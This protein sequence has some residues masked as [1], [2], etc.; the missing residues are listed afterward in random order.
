[1][2]ETGDSVALDSAKLLQSDIFQESR[3]RLKVYTREYLLSF[4]NLSFCQTKPDG[5]D[6]AV[7]RESQTADVS[8]GAVAIP[9]SFSRGAARKDRE[10]E[11]SMKSFRD[12]PE[13]RRTSI[14]PGGMLVHQSSRRKPYDD[15]P[16]GSPFSSSYPSKQAS[17]WG[18]STQSRSNHGR[19]AMQAS[20]SM[21]GHGKW[22]HRGDREREKGRFHINRDSDE[23]DSGHSHAGSPS[24]RPGWN[25]AEHDGLLGSGESLRGSFVGSLVGPSS[26]AAVKY[27]PSGHGGPTSP[28]DDTFHSFKAPSGPRRQGTDAINDETF[29]V[30]EQ[31]S[32]ER[33]EQE[34]QRRES[35]EL[36]RREQKK[37]M[38]EQ[39]TFKVKK[40]EEQHDAKMEQT[41]E[42]IHVKDSIWDDSYH[43]ERMVPSPSS[44]SNRSS[45][46]LTHEFSLLGSALKTPA[47]MSVPSITRPLVPPGFSQEILL[48]TT[49]RKFSDEEKCPEKMEDFKQGG[50]IPETGEADSKCTMADNQSGSSCGHPNIK[51]LENKKSESIE[52]MKGI[53]ESSEE[54]RSVLENSQAATPAGNSTP[55]MSK[56]A[57]WFHTEEEKSKHAAS[58]S[59]SASNILSLFSK[60][61]TSDTISKESL[62]KS[63]EA[64]FYDGDSRSSSS[65]LLPIGN[66]GQVLPMPVGPSLEDIEKDMTLAT[67]GKNEN[68][69]SPESNLKS[70]DNSF[71]QTNGNGRID[72][73]HH[74]R[75]PCS[76]NSV[77]SHLAK[78][79]KVFL[80]CED[81]E[82]SLLAETT[83]YDEQ[84]SSIAGISQSTA[85]SPVSKVG[86]APNH[87]AS[88]Y[89][90]SLLQK[91]SAVSS[92]KERGSR[93]HYGGKEE[94]Q[95]RSPINE[96]FLEG[97]KY[98]QNKD[99][100]V[101]VPTLEAL[102]GKAFMR[103]LRSVE[104]PVSVQSFP[105]EAQ[106]A[107]GVHLLD[108]VEVKQT[109][110]TPAL[111][112]TSSDPLF[113]SHLRTKPPIS[114]HKYDN[115][116][117][118]DGFHSVFPVQKYEMHDEQDYRHTDYL[119]ASQWPPVENPSLLLDMLA[120]RSSKN[121]STGMPFPFGRTSS[122]E[123]LERPI[124]ERRTESG[125]RKK[126][127]LGA[128]VDSEGQGRLSAALGS[129]LLDASANQHLLEEFLIDKGMEG[130]H[131]SQLMLTEQSLRDG[132]SSSV[133]PMVSNASK[134]GGGRNF[135]FPISDKVVLE[136][137]LDAVSSAGGQVYRHTERE[138]LGGISGQL[139]SATMTNAIRTKKG[140]QF[141]EKNHVISHKVTDVVQQS[142]REYTFHSAPYGAH[143]M[144]RAEGLSRDANTDFGDKFAFDNLNTTSATAPSTRISST[145]QQS[146]P[147]LPIKNLYRSHSPVSTFPAGTNISLGHLQ[148]VLVSNDPNSA[149]HLSQAQ[150]GPQFLYSQ[151]EQPLIHHSNNGNKMDLSY[152]GL[153]HQQ[154]SAFARSF[155][156]TSVP[157][158][159]HFQHTRPDNFLNQS[160]I[161]QTSLPR[162]LL[163]SNFP[164]G[165]FP[166]HGFSPS[167]NMHSF[168]H[169]QLPYDSHGFVTKGMQAGYFPLNG[170]LHP[171]MPNLSLPF[172]NLELQHALHMEQPIQGQGQPNITWRARDYS[173][174][175]P[176]MPP[177]WN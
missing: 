19:Q 159:P 89:L 106:A 114:T 146:H 165:Q 40:P 9:G 82:Q 168:M 15:E 46:S 3:A 30:E 28:S 177:H 158:Q 92:P 131:Q 112:A 136:S 176:R 166:Q 72:T 175:L 78:V 22:G 17:H 140:S 98:S 60:S 138:A 63:F 101:S 34:R 91:G 111:H 133:T 124:S 134:Y 96:P 68:L 94:M 139:D 53:E 12:I 39:Q 43:M 171:P 14:H 104:A 81:I 135:D 75:V 155:S 137:V 121:S 58:A 65:L 125:G 123:S 119:S 31:S 4:A 172:P 38:R 79:P 88:Q 26:K 151:L 8:D 157:N 93:R 85:S 56:F 173:R 20:G 45:S 116:K 21:A 32:E 77:P 76:T 120:G 174:R 109:L 71:A 147:S 5:L 105:N 50:V 102:F 170:P 33:L 1:M 99:E 156:N 150:G 67:N 69:S 24:V 161:P 80:T 132:N 90:L 2:G 6:P 141:D 29:G 41:A 152:T 70:D 126:P 87:L 160:N 55:K 163:G 11:T 130:N 86:E 44:S 84:L 117:G 10:S 107:H 100:S 164:R 51:T 52:R 57:K 73:N 47:L 144:S 95:N 13:W 54:S 128:M 110:M 42:K 143:G 64:D 61:A 25:I 16:P 153:R 35:F 48:K 148:Q 66:P 169:E 127:V 18:E 83:G 62:Y 74:V 154:D 36:M 142:N 49:E 23:S 167:T 122:V 59:D 129:M 103:E 162:P 7:W 145:Q 118:G 149:V 108:L 113:D 27:V 97:E 115:N 37:S